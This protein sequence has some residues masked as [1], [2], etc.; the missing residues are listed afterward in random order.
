MRWIVASQFLSARVRRL[1]L[2]APTSERESL[3]ALPVA[4]L[5]AM[6]APAIAQ[7]PTQ[8]GQAP[9]AAPG[10]I[11][12]SPKNGQSQQQQAADRYAC[13]SWAKNQTGF[14][15]TL[16]NGGVSP[17]LE[18]SRRSEYRR[19]IAACLE[20]RGYGVQYAAQPASPP[21]YAAPPTSV[22]A[23]PP[24][25]APN[26]YAAPP[27]MV[28]YS[29]AQPELKYHPFQAQIDGGYT[30]TTGNTKEALNNG[31]NVGLGFTWFPTSN[32]PVGIRVDGSYSSFDAA[33]PLLNMNGTQYTNGHAH[34]YGGDADLQLDLAHRSSRQK[35]YLFGGF[36]W[37][38]EQT[39]LRQISIEKGTVCGFYFCGPGY[40]PAL[41]A[42]DDTTSPWLKSWNAGLGWEVAVADH[43]SFF[44]E[45]RFQ[46]F[47]QN[48]GD[49]QFVPITVGLR[50]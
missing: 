26:A 43:A 18:A 15:P 44:M 28:N 46:H 9:I 30:V 1:I 3:T 34:L 47:L 17:N 20:G 8:Q 4:L 50:F 35:L 48:S 12:I 37:Y 7:S 39:H 10:G 27:R 23:V 22:Y 49:M 33:G 11:S 13:H 31:S 36:G 16:P 38:R 41:T 42:V 19:A 40:F 6:S 25:P 45:A 32:L 2:G 5:L 14:D 24:S 21:V 29:P